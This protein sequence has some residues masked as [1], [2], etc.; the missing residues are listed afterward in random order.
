MNK[1]SKYFSVTFLIGLVLA[2]FSASVFSF[3]DES[4]WLEVRVF[5]K[6]SD[7]AVS[8]A[9]VCLGTTARP[10]QF[11]A[12]RSNEDGVVRFENLGQ[13]PMPLLATVSRQG[14]QGRKQLLEPLYQSRVLVMKIASGGGGPECNAAAE[15]LD[16]TTS[17]GLTV[18]RIDISADSGTGESGNVLISVAASGPVNQIRI[19]EQADFAGAS[20]Q[21]Y[22]PA[23]AHT[24]SQGK[25]LKQVHVQVRRFSEVAGASIEVVSA[26][27]KAR[28]RVQ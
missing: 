26:P 13:K 20:W 25:G 24:L 23:V 21:A 7:R 8:G 1:K 16:N 18:D 9:A 14:F 15:P 3:S 5:N 6:Q 19:S 11:G 4:H 2:A 12:G 10:D 27:K 17:S 22:Q 28:H